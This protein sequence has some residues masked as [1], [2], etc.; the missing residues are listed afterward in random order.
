MFV[1]VNCFQQFCCFT[2]PYQRLFL[3]NTACWFSVRRTDGADLRRAVFAVLRRSGLSVCPSI[4]TDLLMTEIY[5]SVSVWLLHPVYYYKYFQFISLP[6][7]PVEISMEGQSNWI[8]SSC[9]ITFKDV[10]LTQGVSF[11]ASNEADKFESI[12]RRRIFFNV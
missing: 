1:Y 4:R 10:L 11:T 3:V 8:F 6:S 5:L 9:T 12:W 2:L 7:T